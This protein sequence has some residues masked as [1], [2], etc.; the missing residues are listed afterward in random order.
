M[1]KAEFKTMARKNQLTT[2]GQDSHIARER[3][4]QSHSNQAMHKLTLNLRIGY[5]EMD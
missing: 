2:K 5:L 3:N 1:L 4:T